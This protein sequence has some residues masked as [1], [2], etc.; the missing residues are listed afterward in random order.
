MS[1]YWRVKSEHFDPDKPIC[2]LDIDGVLNSVSWV[3]SELFRKLRAERIGKSGTDVEARFD[4]IDPAAIEYLNE[5][6]D[7]NF[8]LSST[9]RAVGYEK[10]QRLLQAVGFKGQL[11]GQTPSNTFD[12][13]RGNEILGW[14]KQNCSEYYDVKR[15]VIFDDDS[16]MLLWQRNNFIHVDGYFGL[17]P[18]HIY[19]AKRICS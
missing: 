13:I 11:C 18:N 10:V 14:L 4:Q 9:W 1:L 6:A 12:N 15:Y 16:D 2:F 19:R 3:K 5:I 7:W 8:V 17:S